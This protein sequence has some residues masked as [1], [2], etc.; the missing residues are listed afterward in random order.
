MHLRSL[1][2]ISWP[3]IYLRVNSSNPLL[4][5]QN[6]TSW[7]NLVLKTNFRSSIQILPWSVFLL[8]PLGPLWA[9]FP[10]KFSRNLNTKLDRISLPSI[11]QLLSQKLLLLV[12]LLWRSV[13]TV[14]RLP[15]RGLKARFRRVPTLKE[16]PGVAMNMP[17]TILRLCIREF[18][19]NR[20]ARHRYEHTCDYFELPGMAMN[21]PVTTLRLWIREFL[22]NREP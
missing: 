8:S 15:L 5:Q 9:R 16:L 17:M 1:N 19:F 13:S 18:L 20:A 7:D 12:T 11:L 21:T 4:Q 3:L 10:Y 2:R 6:I 14:S 22:F